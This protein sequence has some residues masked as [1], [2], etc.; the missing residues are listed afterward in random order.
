MSA[1]NEIARPQGRLAAL[2]GLRGVAALIVVFSHFC[3]A[4]LPRFVP[5]LTDHPS[6][7]ADTPLGILYNGT[8]SVSIFFVLSGFVVARAAAKSRDPFYVN[9]PLRYLRLALP[10]TASVIWAWGLLTLMPTAAT[11]LNE[12]RPSSWLMPNH[13]FQMQ[14]P[15]I[16][17]AL[18]HGLIEIYTTGGSR[19]NN[20]LWTMQIEA[21]GSMA[22]YL[23]YSV[24]NPRA[25]K[26]LAIVIG[27][28]T[29]LYPNYLCFVLGAWMM[30]RWSAGKLK[31]G[32]PIAALIAGILLGFPGRGFAQRLH[33]PYIWHTHGAFDIGNSSSLIAPLAAALILYSVL[34]LEYL[35]RLLS[36]R[37]PA[38]LGRVSFPLY[39][40][41]VP[42]LYTVFSVV[43]VW[44]KPTSSIFLLPLF[45][46]FLGCSFALASAGE[47][48]IDKPVLDGISQARK[49]L[50]AWRESKIELK[51]A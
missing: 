21:A 40:V 1:R 6:W 18:Y 34:N 36:S 23:F 5:A 13:V 20:V 12:L 9:L 42:L 33:I 30:E 11:H 25:R 17:H 15:D 31:F 37:V 3:C 4:F 43:Y 41:H 7:F 50:R 16:F 10:A 45:V 29:L 35:Q 24:N 19:F 22:I 14:I 39:L 47:A 26:G 51:P 44:V 46:A 2:D 8:F 27:L 38:Y 28:G 49:K 32:S 48:W